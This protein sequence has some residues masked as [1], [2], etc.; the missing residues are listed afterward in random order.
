MHRVEGNLPVAAA[1][2]GPDVTDFQDTG[3][4]IQ[5]RFVEPIR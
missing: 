2:P 4:E 3:G 1:E 5:A